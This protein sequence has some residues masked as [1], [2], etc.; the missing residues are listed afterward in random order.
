M[1]LRYGEL[2]AVHPGYVVEV[3]REVEEEEGREGVG[4]D[5]AE[6]GGN[7]WARQQLVKVV[8]LKSRPRASELVAGRYPTHLVA[9]AGALVMVTAR[10]PAVAR[11]V[12]V[13][14]RG[15]VVQQGV[16]VQ[17][18]VVASRLVVV[19]HGLAAFHRVDLV[20]RVVRRASRER[21]GA[22]VRQDVAE[23]ASLSPKG[24]QVGS[25]AEAALHQVS[26]SSSSTTK[27]R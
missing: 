18:L 14:Q 6:E 21:V 23:S 3:L 13:V 17:E 1:V 20:S 19:A 26:L 24:E 5:E 15:V 7:G 2:W 27:S 9:V 11:Q 25:R 16:V 10:G 22:L 8:H 12:V 4:V